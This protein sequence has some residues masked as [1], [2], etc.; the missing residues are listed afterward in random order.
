VSWY[1]TV[2]SDEQYTV[3]ADTVFT[4]TAQ[5][6]EW[7]IGLPELRPT[8]AMGFSSVQPWVSVQLHAC[9]S[10]GNYAH[11]GSFLARVNLVELLSSAGSG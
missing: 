8:G 6:L 10:R 11:N 5:L 4:D 7:L 2:R 3:F 1:L 9:D